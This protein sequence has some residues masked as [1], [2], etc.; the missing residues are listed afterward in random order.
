MI[1]IEGVPAESGSI[2]KHPISLV[3]QNAETIRLTKPGGKPISI[4]KL[5]P[6]DE[7][8]GYEEER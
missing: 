2:E 4:V 1:L 5:K 8:L 3:M 7:V 6:G